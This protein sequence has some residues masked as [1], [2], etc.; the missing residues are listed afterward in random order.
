MKSFFQIVFLLSF[1]LCFGQEDRKGTKRINLSAGVNLSN[2]I[3]S[4]APHKIN[5]YG[6]DEMPALLYGTDVRRAGA[7]FD[8][9]TS[10]I[11][12]TKP[13]LS[14]H[15]EFEYFLKNNLS[16]QTGIAYEEKGI[17]LRAHKQ[18]SWMTPDMSE[19]IGHN[20]GVMPSTLAYYDEFFEVKVE[21]DYVTIPLVCRKYISSIGFFIQA[22]FYVGWLAKSRTQVFQRKHTYT[23]EY[24]Y[25]ESDMIGTIEGTDDKKELTTNID[26][27]LSAGFG[28]AHPLT[29]K[30][31]INASCL[32]SAGFVKI[33]KKYNNE[34]EA[35]VIPQSTGVAMRLRST[36]YFGLNS[37]ARN[38]TA[39]LGIG[40]GYRL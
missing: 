8:Y 37:N 40:L 13:G 22:G 24:N 11:K 32:V 14:I 27:G 10:L 20:L 33:D 4:E 38:M 7:Y 30:L 36:N 15:L 21:N 3:N 23:P 34:Y 1:T 35:Q 19:F 16:L 18:E 12:D 9:N 5:I 26:W 29:N 39:A 25:Y 28:Y 6:S 17:D 31:S 2:L